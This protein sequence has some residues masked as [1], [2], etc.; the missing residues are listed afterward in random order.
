MASRL[1]D[2]VRAGMAAPAGGAPQSSGPSTFLDKYSAYREATARQFRDFGDG[3]GQV[4]NRG[5]WDADGNPIEDS[6]REDE[7]SFR[8]DRERKDWEYKPGV[9]AER[10]ATAAPAFSVSELAPELLSAKRWR[11]D[12]TEF[13]SA[14][15]PPGTRVV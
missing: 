10:V 7:R 13:E 3:R 5:G 2:A 9:L 1:A 4:Y 8:W 14:P 6:E 12:P 15:P 11:R